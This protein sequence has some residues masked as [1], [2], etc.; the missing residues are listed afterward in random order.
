MQGQQ[1]PLGNMLRILLVLTGADC[2]G[3]ID[4]YRDCNANH[5]THNKDSG[6]VTGALRNTGIFTSFSH[7]NLPLNF[8]RSATDKS[9]YGC[10]DK[11]RIAYQVIDIKYIPALLAQ[12]IHTI[13]VSINLAVVDRIGRVHLLL[14]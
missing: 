4:P 12:A 1:P 13:Q 2:H 9:Q 14:V 5:Q 11:V 10:L 3:G 6:P 8:I 7:K